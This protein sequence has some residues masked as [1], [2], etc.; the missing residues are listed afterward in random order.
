MMDCLDN[1]RPRNGH[2]KH[3]DQELVNLLWQIFLHAEEIK[4]TSEP[5]SSNFGMHN[6]CNVWELIDSREK[7]CGFVEGHR[8]QYRNDDDLRLLPQSFTRYAILNG[9]R[10]V[11]LAFER[12]WAQLRELARE[13][14]M[15]LEIFLS[16]EEKSLKQSMFD[17]T[18]I[19]R[20][21]YSRIDHTYSSDPEFP[22]LD[23]Q[24]LLDLLEFNSRRFIE[25]VAYVTEEIDRNEG[26][27][28]GEKICKAM[29]QL[30]LLHR[31]DQPILFDNQDLTTILRAAKRSWIRS[32]HEDIIF[33]EDDDEDDDIDTTY[34]LNHEVLSGITEPDTES[35]DGDDETHTDALKAVQAEHAIKALRQSTAGAP[36]IENE[37]TKL[38][39]LVGEVTEMSTLC[40]TEHRHH[41]LAPCSTISRPGPSADDIRVLASDHK[42][43]P[44][45]DMSHVASSYSL[46]EMASM[47]MQYLSL[48]QNQSD[49]A[50]AISSPPTTVDTKT[51]NAIP[52][53][54]NSTSDDQV[55][56]ATARHATVQ[57]KNDETSSPSSPAGP[58]SVALRLTTEGAVPSKESSFLNQDAKSTTTDAS[59]K[60]A[61]TTQFQDTLVPPS[62]STIAST[63]HT[64][65][66]ALRSS[67]SSLKA[68]LASNSHTDMP[69]LH[70]QFERINQK[71]H[72]ADLQCEYMVKTLT[73]EESDAEPK[74]GK[75]PE[76]LLEE[77]NEIRLKIA[78]ESG[79]PTEDDV[80]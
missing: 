24:Y 29:E 17:D 53:P 7:I 60:T 54:S 21:V 10:H 80:D 30:L 50:F 68:N 18:T 55:Y 73:D 76:E 28:A 69:G 63:F 56:Q 75:G 1:P 42:E 6:H 57:K 61:L 14:P 37:A 39:G 43:E 51:S 12:K 77:I 4:S 31:D 79:N 3:I 46:D 65:L 40:H 59:F 49:L 62:T 25:Y 44:I 48:H 47:C 26:K 27:D 15:S 41:K 72:L 71:A 11:V 74:E 8:C 35:I 19:L 16:Y 45:L 66:L 9:K 20:A 64:Q 34:D 36:A 67:I 2:V 58:L 5:S 33:S 70:S 22:Q 38:P 13:L 32:P 23:S 78:G 52:L